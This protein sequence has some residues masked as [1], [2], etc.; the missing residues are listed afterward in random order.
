[1]HPSSFEEKEELKILAS[2]VTGAT[3]IGQFYSW[4][5]SASASGGKRIEGRGSTCGPDLR[6]NLLQRIP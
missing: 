1:M 6:P 5:K 3:Y 2:M 4:T